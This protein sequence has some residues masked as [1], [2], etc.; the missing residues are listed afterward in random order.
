MSS[1]QLTPRRAA[2]TWVEPHAPASVWL[3]RGITPRFAA[4]ETAKAPLR[5]PVPTLFGDATVP[6]AGTS[7]V[8]SPSKSTR[9]AVARQGSKSS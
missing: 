1:K 9:R 4:S 3:R 2:I 8:A 6:T 5:Q 7:K